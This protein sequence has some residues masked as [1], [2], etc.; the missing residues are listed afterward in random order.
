MSNVYFDLTAELNRE[1]R[2][3]ILASGQAVVW[4]RL[5]ILSKDGDWILRETPG[6]CRRVLDLLARRGAR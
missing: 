3:A 4:Y 2:I 5:A 6:A 1:E